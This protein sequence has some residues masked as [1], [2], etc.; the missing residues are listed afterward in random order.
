MCRK[1]KHIIGGFC[2]DHR[3][4]LTG[5]VTVVLK[6]TLEVKLG[7]ILSS[8]LAAIARE[9]CITV[10]VILLRALLNQRKR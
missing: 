4:V 9:I 10:V 6:L 7:P 3:L 5:L 2:H 8:L 1:S